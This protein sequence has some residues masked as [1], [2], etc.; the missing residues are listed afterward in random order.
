MLDDN[1]VRLSGARRPRTIFE[2]LRRGCLNFIESSE[3]ESNFSDNYGE[4]DAAQRPHREP[5]HKTA[6]SCATWNAVQ[7]IL[8]KFLLQ[9]KEN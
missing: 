2:A 9:N 3:C 1:A 4:S 6:E 7:R 8:C 5:L